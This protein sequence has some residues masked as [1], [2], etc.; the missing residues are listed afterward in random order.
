MEEVSQR[1]N[2]YLTGMNGQIDAIKEMIKDMKELIDVIENI[3]E[4]INQIKDLIRS[5][6]RVIDN[7]IVMY[8]FDSMKMQFLI[9]HDMLREPDIPSTSSKGI[10]TIDLV[11]EEDE[12]DKEPFLFKPFSEKTTTFEKVVPKVPF[13]DYPI[14]IQW[15]KM[16]E[17]HNLCNSESRYVDFTGIFPRINYLQGSSPQEIRYW[18]DFGAINLIYLTSPDFPEISCLP[19]WLKDGVKDC[20]IN[21]PSITTKDILALKFLSAGPDFYKNEGYPA[22]H[23]I[24]IEKYQSFSCSYKN[25]RKIFQGFEENDVHFRRA[26]GIRVVLTSLE[27]A[28]KKGFRTYG[29]DSMLSP[30]MISPA[31]VSPPSAV[32]YLENKI[33]F[34]EKGIIKSSPQAQFKICRYREH[35]HDICP[36]CSKQ[37]MSIDSPKMSQTSDD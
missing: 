9:K 28:L 16:R 1:M 24:Q 3:P 14:E 36:S 25:T 21:N 30:I 26:I 11:S 33:K 17:L 27:A 23:F 4:S 12:K 19:K 10:Q 32:K 20:Y 29:G 22:Y 5:Q 8:E 34:L 31:K 7:K 13:Q 18:Y 15:S 37:N 2:R 6:C 35:T